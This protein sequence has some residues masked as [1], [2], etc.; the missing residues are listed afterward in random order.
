MTTAMRGLDTN[1]LVRHVMGDDPA[2]AAVARAVIANAEGAGERLLV[3]VPVLCELVWTLERSYRLSREQIA[4]VVATLL[5]SPVFVVEERTPARLALHDFE[6]GR[7]GFVDYFVGQLA[8]AQD[9]RTTLTFDE[10]L[11]DHPHFRHPSAAAP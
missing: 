6:R 8:H 10:A 7:A 1:V 2:Q 4:E 9:C 3:T 5:G 11:L